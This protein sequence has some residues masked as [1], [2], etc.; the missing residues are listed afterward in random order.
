[1]MRPAALLTVIVEEELASQLAGDGLRRA[2]AWQVETFRWELAEIYRKVKI[3]RR[4]D[5]I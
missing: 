4:G 3:T 5:Q 2:A 1:M